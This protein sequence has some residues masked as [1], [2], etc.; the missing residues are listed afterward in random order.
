MKLLNGA[1][2]RTLQFGSMAL[3]T[4]ALVACGGGSS[5]GSSPGATISGTAAVGAAMANASVVLTCKNGAG[6]ATANASGAYSATFQ[7]DGPCAITAS[8][9]ATALHS[10]AAGA[11]TYNVTPLTELLLSYLAGQLG[12]TVSGLLSGIS[13]NTT[14]Q[15][16]LSNTTVIANA[17]AAVAQQ[18][19][20]LYGIT[21]SSSSFLTVSFTPGQPGADADLDA[22][23]TAGAITANGQPAAS[24]ITAVT[25]AGKAAPISGGNNGGGTTG[26]T[27]G[28]GGT[29][30]TTK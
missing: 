12:T 27:G 26:G 28:S 18:I 23:K 30:T 22:L 11:G 29:G 2:L 19:K 3:A 25:A 13:N 15:S 6:S 16:A 20:T 24:L 14:F 9:G 8:S 17:Q 10:F 5:N 4:S 7:F 21:L 1:T